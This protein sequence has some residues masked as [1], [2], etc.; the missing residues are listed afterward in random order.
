MIRPYGDRVLVEKLDG[1][2]VDTV[3]P[4]GIHLPGVKF[5]RG[6]TK[7]V[8][9]TF[10]ARVLAVGPK[11]RDVRVGDE[12]IAYTYSREGHGRV[13]TGDETEYGLV[14]GEDDVLAVLEPTEVVPVVPFEL[15]DRPEPSVAELLRPLG[16]LVAQ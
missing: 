10:R 12:V 13:L 9:D 2:G 11:V 16:Y 14:L 15:I 5:A 6:K 4:G 3:S 7:H 1:E 8:P